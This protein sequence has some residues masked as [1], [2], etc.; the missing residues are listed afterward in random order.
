M[1]VQAVRTHRI[2]SADTD[3]LAVIDQHVGEMPDGSVLAIASKVVAIC[4]GRVV[5]KA[6]ASKDALVEQ[7]AELYLPRTASR[8]DVMLTIKRSMVIPTAGIDESNADGVYVLWPADPQR[9]ANTIWRHVRERFGRARVGVVITDSRTSPLRRGV[10]G[11][12]VSHCGFAALRSQLGVRDLYGRPLEMTQIN[13]MDALAG[14]AVFVMGEAAEQTPLA[15]I[16]D[17]P[18]I[19]FTDR[20]P[21]EEEVRGLRIDIEDDLYGPLL[22]RVAWRRGG[23]TP[24]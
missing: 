4:E 18:H 15:V 6:S 11:I 17:L 7:E 24:E 12:A 5:D 22:S 21:T 10:T 23:A 3:I 14:A 16:D 13:V 8:F 19:A 20:E 1:N 2:T 9:S